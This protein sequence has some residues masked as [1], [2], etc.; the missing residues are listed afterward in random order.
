MLKKIPL[1]KEGNP[2]SSDLISNGYTAQVADC[3]CLSVEGILA[4]PQHSHLRYVYATWESLGVSVGESM[5]CPGLKF[6]F[7][8]ANESTSAFIVVHCSLLSHLACPVVLTDS[9]LYLVLQKKC[10]A[11]LGGLLDRTLTQWIMGAD[12][13]SFEL[14]PCNQAA[15]LPCYPESRWVLGAEWGCELWGLCAGLY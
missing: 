12:D 6:T 11:G 10:A 14:K 8:H 4:P 7:L 9:M 3:A 15:A 2:F 1:Q 5:L 13:E